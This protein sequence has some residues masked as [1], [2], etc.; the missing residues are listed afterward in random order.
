MGTPFHW[1]KFV[2]SGG[3][4]VVGIELDVVADEEIEVTVAV[5]VEE[6]AA[7]S[8]AALFLVE[9]GFVGDVSEGAVAV[10][11]EEN[12]VSPEAAE[13]IVPSIVVVVANADAG[14]PSGAPQS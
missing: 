12:V 14:L 1:Q 5:V 11:V 8:P 13:Q 2:S 7:S 10:V 3:G 6:R 4:I 9:A